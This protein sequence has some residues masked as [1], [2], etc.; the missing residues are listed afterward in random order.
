MLAIDIDEYEQLSGLPRLDDF[1]EQLAA[2]STAGL[3]EKRGKMVFPTPKGMFYA[4][5]I[6]SLLVQA[7]KAAFPG[8]K[9]VRRF[10]HTLESDH[11]SNKAGYM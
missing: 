9:K 10:S 6:A 11:V 4:D 8:K 7:N 1:A 5:A 2:L 3:I